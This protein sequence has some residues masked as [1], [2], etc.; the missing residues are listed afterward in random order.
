MTTPMKPAT[1]A[2]V[3]A[4]CGVS[5]MTVSRVVCGVR[6]VTP[7]TKEKVEAA[8]KKLGY[9]PN[10]FSRALASSRG[11]AADGGQ[12]TWAV[13]AFLDSDPTGYGKDMF[14]FLAK[15]GHAQGYTLKYHVFPKNLDQ[16]RYLS[17][18]LYSQ[19]IRGVILG[20]SQT[21]VDFSGLNMSQFAVISIGALHHVP[22][23]DSV[24]QDYFQ[25]MY[26]AASKCLES[27]RRHIGFLIP[28]Q[29]E[30]RTHHRWLG[31][32][33]AFCLQH[34]IKPCIREYDE[35]KP[36]G[37]KGV[38]KWIEKNKIDVFITLYGC[39]TR[40]DLLDA[41][42]PARAVLLSDLVVPENMPYISIP[43][44][45]IARETIRLLNQQLIL[46]QYGAP[47][48]SYQISIQG[49]WNGTL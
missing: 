48:W 35:M 2:D 34:K 8:I 22:A 1:L 46:Q 31:A 3:A 25:S 23:I 16:Q 30:V 37:K 44:E 10:P 45:L 17:N 27:G 19:G 29:T 41:N 42:L 7:K 13:V 38:L 36:P 18:R 32:Y 4:L 14:D 47:Q 9:R 26:L 28:G 21:E 20:P 15:E 12:S 43:M 49:H 24:S 39:M 40:N 11:S 5:A 33:L 6:N